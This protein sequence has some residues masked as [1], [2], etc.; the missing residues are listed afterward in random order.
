MIAVW[1]FVSA[2]TPKRATC[3]STPS[4][5]VV[6]QPS[7]F[8]ARPS[9]AIVPTSATWP[10]LIT[11]MIRPGSKPTLSRNVNVSTK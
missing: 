1:S 10:M 5:N 3:P 4:V 7:F 6:F 11:G 2:N 9:T 8:S